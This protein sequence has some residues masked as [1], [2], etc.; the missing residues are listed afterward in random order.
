[1]AGN[2]MGE[3]TKANI[4]LAAE[5]VF[6][7]KGFEKTKVED[8]A[9]SAGVTRVMLYYHFNTK[10]NI[11]NEIVKEFIDE[12]KNE[13]Q[14]NLDP[15]VLG[16]PEEFRTRLAAMQDFYKKKQKILR[17]VLSE[18][19]SNRH[20]DASTLALFNEI[21]SLI[22]GLAGKDAGIEK[23]VFLVKVFFFN[24]MPMMMYSCIE[25]QFC[26]NFEIAPEKC[27]DIFS[28]TFVRVFYDNLSTSNR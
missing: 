26:A 1:M 23:E 17:L 10:Q 4:L 13:F 21:F 24:A 25:D 22:I 12:V 14:A 28:D 3:Q 5:K 6:M 27:L 20:E 2:K 11:F 7:E 8:I 9:L 15:A 19:I 18:Y 16:S